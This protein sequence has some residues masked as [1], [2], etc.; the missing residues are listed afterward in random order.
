MTYPNVMNFRQVSATR[1]ELDFTGNHYY[2]DAILGPKWAVHKVSS[3]GAERF[4]CNFPFEAVDP[5]LV[6]CVLVVRK[7]ALAQGKNE[8]RCAQVNVIRSALLLDPAY[9]ELIDDITGVQS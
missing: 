2:V 7:L 4:I 8:G 3:T 6:R 1:Y 9:P 5:G